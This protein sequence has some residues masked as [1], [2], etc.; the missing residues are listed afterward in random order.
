M[1]LPRSRGW[2]HSD[3]ALTPVGKESRF[4]QAQQKTEGTEG[5]EPLSQGVEARGDGPPGDGRVVADA[6]P[7]EVGQLSA[8]PIGK[9]VRDQKDVHHERV[10]AGAQSEFIPD[11]GSHDGEG[12]AVQVIDH[13]AHEQHPH[14]PPADR[15]SPPNGCPGRSVRREISVCQLHEVSLIGSS[16]SHCGQGFPRGFCLPGHAQLTVRVDQN[17]EGL[18]RRR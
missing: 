9:G 15:K 2:N 17:G 14:D 12:D 10:V 13:A 7:E 11:H 5:V 16:L 1:G 8:K 4:A 6:C 18:H 3:M